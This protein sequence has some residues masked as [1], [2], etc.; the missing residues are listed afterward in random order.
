MN[1]GTLVDA[2]DNTQP[3]PPSPDIMS[4][5]EISNKSPVPTFR[6]VTTEAVTK[7]RMKKST[8]RRKAKKQSRAA[9]AEKAKPKRK[10]SKAAK[11]KAKPKVVATPKATAKRA[12]PKA[13]KADRVE[14]AHRSA[15]MRKAD[16]TLKAAIVAKRDEIGKLQQQIRR[17]E[18]QLK[19]LE[20]M[21]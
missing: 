14:V 7:K 6:E 2:L 18:K 4:G 5:A 13:G 8:S 12:K 9:G 15:K 10:A 19:T 17:V 1:N 21:L 16:P 11:E 20:S 3:M